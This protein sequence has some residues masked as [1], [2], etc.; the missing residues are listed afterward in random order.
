M[1]GY[2]TR[3]DGDFDFVTIRGSGHMVPAN[4]PLVSW[5]LI[6]NWLNKENWLPYVKPTPS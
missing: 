3:Y 4:K 5:H 6:N 2:V 1:G